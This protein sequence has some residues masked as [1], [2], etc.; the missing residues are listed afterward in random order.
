[1]VYLLINNGHE[2]HTKHIEDEN[3]IK[4]CQKFDENSLMKYKHYNM[5]HQI[6]K[7]RMKNYILFQLKKLQ[8]TTKR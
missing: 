7:K 3:V 2:N 8:K 1:M 4:I 5:D 6:T